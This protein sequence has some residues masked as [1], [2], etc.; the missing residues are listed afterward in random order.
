MTLQLP[1][2]L[3]LV[4]ALAAAAGAVSAQETLDAVEPAQTDAVAQNEEP[5]AAMPSP[6]AGP[7]SSPATASACTGTRPA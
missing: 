2:R 5:E 1:L 4:A 7:T 3:A 6:P